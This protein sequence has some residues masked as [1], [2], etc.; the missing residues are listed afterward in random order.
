MAQHVRPLAISRPTLD[1]EFHPC[2]RP[3]GFIFT[4]RAYLRSSWNR[5]DAIIVTAVAFSDVSAAARSLRILRVLRPLRLISRIEGLRVAVGLLLES[6][7]RVQ[8]VLL[9]YVVFLGTFAILGVQLLGGML[10]SCD[11]ASELATRSAC[12]AGGHK[13]HPP[14][15]GSFDN[16]FASA[17][18]LFEL[19]AVEGWT[20]VLYATIDA[21]GVD[22][23]P[24]RDHSL[25]QGLF[26]IAWLL[27]GAFLLL[28]LIAGVVVS[29]YGKMKNKTDGG[30]AL[31]T[32]RQRDWTEMMSQM[33]TL[34]PRRSAKCPS[35]PWR[36]A[37]FHVVTHAR[38]E[39]T[40]ACVIFLNTLVLAA[41]GYGL[42]PL[43]A[44]FLNL[45]NTLCALIFVAEAAAKLAGIGFVAYF[46]DPWHTFDF[47]IVLMTLAEWV[48]LLLSIIIDTPTPTVMRILRLVRVAR[49]LRT[50]RALRWARGLVTMLSLLVLSL[51]ALANT[52][53][54]FLLLLFVYSL[55]GMALFGNVARG[56][57]ISEDAHFCDFPHA[58]LT[59]FRCSTGEDWNGLMHDAMVSP[60]SGRCS[61][62]AGD[63]GS[64]LAVP[65]FVSFVLF[66]THL[67]LKMIVALVLENYVNALQRDES[68][69]RP[70][71]AEAFVEAWAALDP[72]ATGTIPV[73][74]LPNLIR[75][76]PPPLGLDP[77]QC[78]LRRARAQYTALA[79]APSR[80]HNPRLPPPLPLPRRAQSPSLQALARCHAPSMTVGTIMLGFA[81]RTST[82]TPISSILRPDSATMACSRSALSRCSPYSCATRTLKT[83]CT[84]CRLAVPPPA[85]GA[86][87]P[88]C[89]LVVMARSCVVSLLG[90]KMYF[91]RRHL[92][93]ACGCCV[94]SPNTTL[95][96]VTRKSACC[97]PRVLLS[98]PP[99]CASTSP[100]E[101][102]N[103]S[104]YDGAKSSARV[105]RR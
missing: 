65:F 61:V 68:S 60:S 91:R 54:I 24:V 21:V 75:S 38:F 9:I 77:K 22:A 56:N 34:R 55:L 46:L 99:R 96:R 20:D 45:L 67:V 35:E 18:L 97:R 80:A 51:P 8:Q 14:S 6:L 36:A 98:W 49:V 103:A 12:E 66:S 43:Q 3:A 105:G 48:I 95:L 70:A 25:G 58:M 44:N 1:A 10:S 89:R 37:C 2:L 86:V 31:M 79:I 33:L 50:L 63:C 73:T 52:L 15:W 82:D 92:A 71:H 64:W 30:G 11:G 69:L 100:M 88:R 32:E 94:S 19:S 57:Y 28:N 5:L 27:L 78:A 85:H 7:P 101:S 76:L 84:L 40:I 90:G 16:V 72:D 13:W 59:M 39:V 104:P 81:R 41:D 4:P 42:S 23:A 62:E 102:C 83:D 87:H 47:S 74:Q 26:V 93:L 29:T 17:L 53:G